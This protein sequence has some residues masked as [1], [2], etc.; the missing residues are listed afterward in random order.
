MII[1]EKPTAIFKIEKIIKEE[2]ECQTS[3]SKKSKNT[4]KRSPWSKEVLKIFNFRK[5]ML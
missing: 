1:K 2:N 5:M 3:I 4:K